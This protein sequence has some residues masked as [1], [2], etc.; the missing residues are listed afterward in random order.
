[1]KARILLISTLTIVFCLLSTASIANDNSPK[2]AIIIDDIGYRK[3][4]FSALALQGQFTYSVVPFA[5]YTRT[6]ANA[7]HDSD[8]EVMAH[9]PMEAIHNNHLLGKG[10]LKLAMTEQQTRQQ[11]QDILKEIPYVSG[12]NNHMG[13]Q[14]TTKP[15]NLG[16]LMDELSQQQ[17]YFLDSKTTAYSM[18]EKVAVEHGLRTGHR[19]IFLDNQL[20]QAYLAQQFDHL[21]KIAKRHKYAIAIAHPHPQSISFLKGISAKLLALGV[22][23]VPVSTL[24]P[25]MTRIAR[26]RHLNNKSSANKRYTGAAAVLPQ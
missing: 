17:L 7:V 22:E 1:M 6:I 21:I 23:L 9:I 5:P 13:S 2:I 3:T 8:R 12:I 16:W 26:V 14:F 25:E 4:D 11:V 20:D 10:A 18:A 19:H 15:K 24:L